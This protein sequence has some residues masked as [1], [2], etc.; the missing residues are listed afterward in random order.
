MRIGR[1]VKGIKYLKICL[2]GELENYKIAIFGIF[3]S[4]KLI[5]S[6]RHL[7]GYWLKFTSLISKHNLVAFLILLTVEITHRENISITCTPDSS[8]YRSYTG[9]QLWV[10]WSALVDT[11]RGSQNKVTIAVLKMIVMSGIV[12]TNSL[13]LASPTCFT[14][15][16]FR[17]KIFNGW[18]S[19]LDFWKIFENCT[20]TAEKYIKNIALHKTRYFEVI[21]EKTGLLPNLGRTIR[22]ILFLKRSGGFK[23]FYSPVFWKLKTWIVW[24]IYL[25][26]HRNSMYQI[27]QTF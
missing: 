1:N 21:M 19:F 11:G 25:K 15:L 2:V 17:N 24:Y 27:F 23:K 16:K 4:K 14:K 13:Q 5:Q 10:S 9:I 7:L 12:K 3:C 22:S 18:T 20:H 26:N 8:Q 6:A